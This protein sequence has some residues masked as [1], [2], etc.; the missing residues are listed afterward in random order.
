MPVLRSGTF[1]LYGYS[2]VDPGT[3]TDGIHSGPPDPT[4]WHLT[5]TGS[6]PTAL[7][8]HVVWTGPSLLDTSADGT[9]IAAGA[10]PTGFR[11]QTVATLSAAPAARLRRPEF[12][13]R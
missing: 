2:L 13:H 7:P 8:C 12:V 6:F 3:L 11:I 5:N 1:I 9:A 4:N 10:P